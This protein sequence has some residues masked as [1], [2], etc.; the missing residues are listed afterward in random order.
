MRIIKPNTDKEKMTK[1]MDFINQA[2]QRYLE[3]LD[4]LQKQMHEAFLEEFGKN[5]MLDMNSQ[6]KFARL[7]SKFSHFHAKGDLRKLPKT[8]E[9]AYDLWQKHKSEILIMNSEERRKLGRA[10][11]RLAFVYLFNG[12][13]IKALALILDYCEIVKEDIS[14]K[15]VAL[16]WLLYLGETELAEQKLHNWE[17]RL[18]QEMVKLIQ[19]YIGFVKNRDQRAEMVQK[20]LK[21]VEEIKE[22]GLK[23]KSFQSYEHIS[24]AS[25][26]LST[27]ASSSLISGVQFPDKTSQLSDASGKADS[28]IRNKIDG[29]SPFQFE[30]TRSA[31][32]LEY[33]E[34]KS[35]SRS[36]TEYLSVG[37][38]IAWMFEL[39]KDLTLSYINSAQSREAM[40]AL[41]VNWRIALKSGC[42]LRI[43]QSVNL[44]QY[45]WNVIN[46]G[47]SVNYRSILAATSV[48]MLSPDA[49]IVRCSTPIN[50]ENQTKKKDET[51]MLTEGISDL[52]IAGS[53]PLHQI[54]KTCYCFTCAMY[55][56]SSNFASE[57]Q[58][59]SMIYFNFNQ[60][61]MSEFEKIFIKIRENT[62]KYQCILHGDEKIRPR[63]PLNLNIIFGISAIRWLTLKIEGKEK[64]DGPAS[65]KIVESALKIVRYVPSRTKELFLT[66]SQLYRQIEHPQNMN[67]SWMQPIDNRPFLKMSIES[68]CDI[69]R[70]VSP[71]GKSKKIAF[72]FEENG[73]GEELDVK[74]RLKKE[75]SYDM[76]RFNHTLYRE[77]RS[78]L[79]TYIGRTTSDQWEAAYSW[80]ESTSIGTRNSLQQKIGQT[81]SVTIESP[82]L[83]RKCVEKM[84]NEM[85]VVQIARA[86][87]GNIY[88]IKL[89]SDR[90]PII[91]PIAHETKMMEMMKKF[92]HLLMEDERISKNPGNRTAEQ[93]WETRKAI[94]ARM[95]SLVDEIQKNFLGCA[96][97][98]LLPST[99]LG[100]K[101]LENAARYEKCTKGAIRIG[102]AKEL[103][104][105]TTKMTENEWKELL[106]RFGEMRK[107]GE[108]EMNMLKSSYHV[109]LNSV[110]NDGISSSSSISQ[111]NNYSYLNICPELAQFCWEKLPIFSNHPYVCR[112]ISIHALF[113]QLETL[114]DSNKEVPLQIDV[115][116]AYYVLDPENNLGE[117]KKRMMEY[118]KKFQWE[119]TVGAA[120]NQSEVVGA[121]E[122]KDAF[123]YFGHG[124]GSKHVTRQTIKQ[125]KCNA[126]SLLMGCGSVKTVP[127]G[128]GFDG[129]SV[130]QDYVVAKC[131][132]V[133]GCLWTVTDGEIDRYLM[134]MV[135]DCFVRKC[136]GKEGIDK[137]R[138]LSE[139]METAKSKSKLKFLTGASVVMYGFPIVSKPESVISSK[140][141]EMRVAQTI[142]GYNRKALSS[143]NLPQ[144]FSEFPISPLPSNAPPQSLSDSTASAAK[145]PKFVP[146]RLRQIP[147]AETLP[148]SSSSAT[149][150]R[151]L[152]STKK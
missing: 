145:S 81:G 64:Y 9:I 129:K 51:M 123:F 2:V 131:P 27:L 45:Y 132:L 53:S 58:F 55:S 113:C 12:E 109:C 151:V 143:I 66:I 15:E 47:D 38:S 40:S 107:I 133:V 111:Q 11:T 36:A 21:I 48:N 103:I 90:T 39:R 93:F 50:E 125:S 78:Q 134:S 110:K 97:A 139:A 102:E 99:K 101:C 6:A 118:I 63:P 4:E 10:P 8:L 59:A 140:S 120:P 141:D 43:L 136:E 149:P 88:L 20:L 41:I 28:I 79:F 119:G 70:A 25:W 130:L 96:A 95:K 7:T 54:S 32:L 89:H 138:Q 150:T 62:M 80:I 121:L 52:S 23:K 19:K 26:M 135:D 128:I 105:L 84:A 14:A 124:S 126:I 61:A 17:S 73:N 69:F 82:Q 106:D 13:F 67:L 24:M 60:Q 46:D 117:T 74:N 57:Y 122:N 100:R 104:Y 65:K 98:L 5:G 35:G 71:F 72:D 68:A 1:S 87:D 152:R 137:L 94:D 147:S 115:Q 127:Q 34:P 85:T 76:N 42:F 86:D 75:L 83:F 144:Q 142:D 116:K 148:T 56:S 22:I 44:T 37:S 92:Q 29:L 77:W 33:L 108:K 18:S 114:R 30:N 16:K 49:M 112:V 31:S 3:D 146:R 91:M